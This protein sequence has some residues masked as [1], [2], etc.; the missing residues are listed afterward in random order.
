MNSVS[1]TSKIRDLAVLSHRRNL[2]R[3]R[4]LLYEIETHLRTLVQPDLLAID[5]ESR[6]A[7]QTLFALDEVRILLGQ[8]DFGPAAS[9][10]RDAVREWTAAGRAAG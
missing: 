7:Q 2:A 6:R 5:P 8:S 10:A 3:A 1:L 4:P 9:A